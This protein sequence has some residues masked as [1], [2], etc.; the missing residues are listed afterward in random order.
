MGALSTTGLAGGAALGVLL[1]SAPRPE[2]ALRQLTGLPGASGPATPVVAA[3]AL[4]AWTLAAWLVLA[5]LLTVLGRAPGRLGR[6][7]RRLARRWVPAAV[8]SG[9]ELALGLSVATGALGAGT[10]HAA[11]PV[12]HVGADR[13]A[14][15]LS[16]EAAARASDDAAVPGPTFDLDWPPPAADATTSPTV[17]LVEPPAPRGVA[18]T[19]GGSPAAVGT[20]VP[21]T[22]PPPARADLVETP[23]AA[24]RAPS[25]AAEAPT[26]AA[27]AGVETAASAAPGTPPAAPATPPARAGVVTTPTSPA[28]PHAVVVVQPGDTLW[29]LAAAS[30]QQAGVPEPSDACIARTWPRWWAANRDVIGPD[31][32]LILPGMPLSP[33]ADAAPVRPGS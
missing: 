8:R 26:P 10:G 17:P 22:P 14:S 24:S 9:L 18:V 27:R 30:L 1:A 6:A 28:S 32:D 2:T 31:P 5:V 29:E 33:P 12:T 23:R 19:P 4:A 21:S 3:A 16:S 7:A 11:A 25:A 20:Q 13:A 15:P